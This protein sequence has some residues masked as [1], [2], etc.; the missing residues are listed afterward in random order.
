M[1]YL[2]TP[3]AKAFCKGFVL[4]LIAIIIAMVCLY[5]PPL[6]NATV[7]QL[8]AIEGIGYGVAC[9]IEQYMDENPN[10]KVEDLD[11]I[12]WVGEKKIEKIRKVFR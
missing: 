8:D 11:K 5:R 2:K 10:A 12:P 7:S 9:Q 3:T 1:I 4:T 6:E